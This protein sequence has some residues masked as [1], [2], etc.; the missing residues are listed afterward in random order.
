[1]QDVRAGSVRGASPSRRDARGRYATV[2]LIQSA[3][4]STGL[5]D[6]WKRK[7]GRP[8]R[9]IPSASDGYRGLDRD[10]EPR[11]AEVGSECLA[12][13]RTHPN[14]NRHSPVQL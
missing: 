6:A 5:G 1:M 4:T 9:V 2:V 13:G 8:G 3:M 11:Y 7:A 14:D 12:C 10:V